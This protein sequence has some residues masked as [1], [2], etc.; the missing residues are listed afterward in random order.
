MDCD[1]IPWEVI[2]GIYQFQN[3]PFVYYQDKE[4]CETY[5]KFLC[6]F[7]DKVVSLRDG[8][9]HLC[10]FQMNNYVMLKTQ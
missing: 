9:L 6:D 8:C 4:V 2:P 3:T 1:K 10:S 5:V 7:L